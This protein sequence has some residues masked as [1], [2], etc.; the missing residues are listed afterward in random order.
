LFPDLDVVPTLLKIIYWLFH[1]WFA[2]F[3][4]QVMNSELDEH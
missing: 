3:D 2:F 1:L 4:V